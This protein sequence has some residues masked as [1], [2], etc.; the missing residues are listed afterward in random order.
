MKKL[1]MLS[2]VFCFFSLSVLDAQLHQGRVLFGVSTSF[3]FVNFGSD[4]MSL[5]FTTVKHKSNAPGYIES[6]ADKTTTIN[7]I[8]KVGYFIADN[9][10]IGLDFSLSSYIYKYEDSRN[11][12]TYL[13]VGPFTRYYIP[14]KNVM[15][16]LEISS[17]FGSVS[18][19][20]S[21]DTS[22]DSYKYSLMSLGG[23]AG[24]AVKMGDKVT[25][26]IMAGYNSLTEKAKENNENN[27][28]T[29]WG[30]FGIKLGFVYILGTN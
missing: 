18:E 20:Y 5:G 15:P 30:T 17:L 8:P 16:F 12:I 13:G 10:V 25:F 23:G 22:D 14:G 9:F 7:L 3:N 21:S 27:E 6:A 29:I 24:M 28:R 26:D 11:S 2:L 4:F 19:K 1:I